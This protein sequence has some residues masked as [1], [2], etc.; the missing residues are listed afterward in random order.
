MLAFDA[1]LRTY[2]DA[3]IVQTHRDPLTVMASVGSLTAVLYMR[4]HRWPD[5]AEIGREVSRRWTH[6]IERALH[7]RRSGRVAARTASS[8]CTTTT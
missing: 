5:L 2:P 1:L 3:Q 8:T 6:G 7:F 4:V